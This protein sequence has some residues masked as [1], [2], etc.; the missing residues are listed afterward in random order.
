MARSQ[1]GRSGTG[2][3]VVVLL[4]LSLGLPAAGQVNIKFSPVEKEIVLKRI[5]EVPK[6]NTEREQK[7]RDLFAEAGC[8]GGMT[9]QK[10][11]YSGFH[12]IIC[13]LPGETEEIII[14][15]AHYDQISPAL[16]V[17]DNWSGASLLSSLYQSLLRSRRHH[18]FLFIS[19]CE[20]EHGLIGSDFYASHMAKEDI[21]RTE[22]MI[23]LDT[24]GL[25]PTKVWVHNADKHLVS[26]LAAVANAL[27]LP[28]SEMDV[29]AVGSSDSESFAGKHIPRITIHSVTQ[30]TLHILHSDDDNLK[31][32]QPDDYYDTYRLVSGYLAYLDETLQP[33]TVDKH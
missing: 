15:G 9:E 30:K 11:K 26:A 6:K 28:A 19:F 23:N 32:L 7:I 21:A 17:M 3:S 33:R 29:E 4:V 1:S 18:T 24:L 14:V 25:S 12:N 16:G 22:A 5:R 27:K 31:Q 20:E 13:R 8:N 10:V 2:S